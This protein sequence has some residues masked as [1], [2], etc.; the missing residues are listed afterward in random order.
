MGIICR[1]KEIPEHKFYF[2]HNS[3]CNND[4]KQQVFLK[5]HKYAGSGSLQAG[6]G[7]G[8]QVGSGAGA[9][10]MKQLAKS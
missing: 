6:S 9:E 8:A 3:N 10:S 7:A 4:S 2:Q 5:I 1:N